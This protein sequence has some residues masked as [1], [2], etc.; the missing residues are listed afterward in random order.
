MNGKKKNLNWISS[1]GHFWL[2]TEE[3]RWKSEKETRGKELKLFHCSCNCPHT[4]KPM[5]GFLLFSKY[6]LICAFF[7]LVCCVQFG[8]FAI[9]NYSPNKKQ[10]K[11]YSYEMAECRGWTLKSSLAE[12]LRLLYFALEFTCIIKNKKTQYICR[13]FIWLSY[14]SIFVAITSTFLQ[15]KILC[16][17]F[18]TYHSVCCFLCTTSA[19]VEHSHLIS[20][21]FHKVL[22]TPKWVAWTVTFF[23]LVSNKGLQWKQAGTREPWS[24][25]VF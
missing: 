13:F 25:H 16:W 8:G 18:E 3:G 23:F 17:L 10:W 6:N 1:C 20:K 11:E 24:K 2:K 19:F 9:L 15:V 4:K 14:N 7:W 5:L 12:I 22:A 21:L